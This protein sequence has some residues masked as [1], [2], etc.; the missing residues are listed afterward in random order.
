MRI[1][2]WGE[3]WVRLQ[4]AQR[5]LEM[6]AEGKGGASLILFALQGSAGASVSSSVWRGITKN[7]KICLTKMRFASFRSIF[8]L[9][10]RGG[11]LFM[12]Y[13]CQ[14]GSGL[15]WD[16][17]LSGGGGGGGIEIESKRKME[18]RKKKKTTPTQQ[19]QQKPARRRALISRVLLGLGKRLCLLRGALVLPGRPGG[20]APGAWRGHFAAGRSGTRRAGAAGRAGPGAG[21]R[22]GQGEADPARPQ[23]GAGKGREGRGHRRCPPSAAPRAAAPRT[24]AMAARR[25][26]GVMAKGTRLQPEGVFIFFFFLLLLLVLR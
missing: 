19:Q 26:G 1:W 16:G 21:P 12:N 13:S 11:S 22:C 6:R 14:S 18:E 24:S 9:R 23:L 3:P 25:C 20:A 2:C 4:K 8:T 10:A 17:S 7:G 15:A 5:Y